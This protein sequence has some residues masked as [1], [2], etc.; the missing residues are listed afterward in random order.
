MGEIIIGRIAT[1]E[2]LAFNCDNCGAEIQG[3]DWVFCNHDE[4]HICIDCAIF[5]EELDSYKVKETKCQV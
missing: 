4:S 1:A 2:E 5:D 3:E